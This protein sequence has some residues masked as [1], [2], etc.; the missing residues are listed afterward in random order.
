MNG[1]FVDDQELPK[2]DGKPWPLRSGHRI[3]FGAVGVTY[4][5]AAEFVLLVRKL[6]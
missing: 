2:R 5:E 3:R 1:T 6:A 4:L